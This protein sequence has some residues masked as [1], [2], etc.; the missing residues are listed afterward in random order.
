SLFHP[1]ELFF[2][3]MGVLDDWLRLLLAA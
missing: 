1:P 2:K 3:R